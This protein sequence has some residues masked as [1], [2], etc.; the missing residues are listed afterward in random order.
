MPTRRSVL[1]MPA[2]AAAAST[3][4]AVPAGT[5]DPDLVRDALARAAGRPAGDLAGDETF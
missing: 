1:A 5:L 3:L 4:A 2:V